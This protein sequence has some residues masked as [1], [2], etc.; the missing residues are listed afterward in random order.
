MTTSCQTEWSPARKLK[1]GGTFVSINHLPQREQFVSLVVRCC[2]SN[3]DLYIEHKASCFCLFTSQSLT[4]V[5]LLGHGIIYVMHLCSVQFYVSYVGHLYNCSIGIYN[6]HEI[7]SNGVVYTRNKWLQCNV[8]PIVSYLWV[9]TS[10]YQSN[11]IQSKV[12]FCQKI[13]V[14]QVLHSVWFC[15]LSL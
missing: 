6:P 15:S 7:W 12:K 2:A 3:W 1:R 11:S 4:V 5:V 8:K 10:A 14:M 9:P 13:N